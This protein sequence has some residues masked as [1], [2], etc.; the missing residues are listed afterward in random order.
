MMSQEHSFQQIIEML[1]A[2]GVP[3]RQL[4]GGGNVAVTPVGGRIVAMAF[5]PS[6][7]NLF[8]TNPELINADL[9]RNHPEKLAGG[10]GGDRIWFAPELDYHWRGKPDW[11]TCSNYE[12]PTSADP[13]AYKF[14]S[15]AADAVTLRAH[16]VLT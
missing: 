2:A 15:E 8:W 12:V 11:N 9:V 3:T 4:A 10:L 5:S 14:V 6:D 7:R 1:S 16:I 13:G